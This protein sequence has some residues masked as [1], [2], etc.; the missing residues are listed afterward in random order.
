MTLT[1]ANSAP[2]HRLQGLPVSTLDF[3][4]TV[5]LVSQKL[6]EGS[7]FSVVT[8]N[9]DHFLRWHHSPEFRHLYENA[10]LATV[11][12]AILVAL[13]KV[14]GVQLH[15]VTGIDLFTAMAEVAAYENI[16][17]LLI[18]GSED[19]SQRAVANL[20]AKHPT[21]QIPLAISP[22]AS[23]LES[24]AWRRTLA[25]ELALHPRKLVALCLGSPKQERLLE[26][27][28]AENPDLTGVFL[29]VG[30]A[31]DF[32]AGTVSR[33]PLWMQK[34]GL[35][36]LF[37]LLSEPGRLWRRYLV[38]DPPI[39]THF[40][41]AALRRRLDTATRATSAEEPLTV[42]QVGLMGEQPGGIA[43]VVNEYLTWQG[44]N[45]EQVGVVSTRFKHDRM[46]PLLTLKAALQL[47]KRARSGRATVASFHLSERG[48]F[49]REGALMVWAHLLGIPTIAHLHGADFDEFQAAHPRLTAN[50]LKAANVVAVLT[51]S[52]AAS[53][54]RLAPKGVEVVKVANP[55]APNPHALDAKAN[56][57]FFGG[58]LSERKG[59][60]T[61]LAAWREVVKYHPDWEL[62]LAGPVAADF[63]LPEL[64]TNTRL[65]G[66]LTHDQLLS[67][68]ATSAVAVLP[69]R[70]EALPVFILEAMAAKCAVVSSTAGQIPDLL[71]NGAGLMIQPGNTVDLT[72]QLSA[73]VQ[74]PTL[75]EQLAKEGH[76]RYAATY[77]SDV[78]RRQL[79]G[80]WRNA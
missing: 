25:A 27:L 11:D 10:H 57:L 45:I 39:L 53:V 67:E 77:A 17:L 34:N 58:E 73:V 19:T 55:V 8:P 54:R 15:R 32:T 62:V 36:W 4:E 44:G 29:C 64:P 21:L 7:L 60:D 74:Y 63:T 41:W 28:R 47:L 76:H 79:E 12:G 49:V 65:L 61:L 37:R 14:A 71:G 16:P 43:Q 51:D 22:T 18:G 6:V 48:S 52:A 30:A 42:L 2:T 5:N 80:I 38:D 59:V 33:A 46:A 75:R 31:I 20:T 56:R 40:A 24:P 50:V 35:E 72:E 9:T 26:L 1:Y 70:H 78:A 69:S 23:E 3:G 66:R 68:L 13:G